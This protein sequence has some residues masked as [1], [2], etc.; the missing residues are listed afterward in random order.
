MQHLRRVVSLW[1][2]MDEYTHNL[3]K[4][5]AS[6]GP[7]EVTFFSAMSVLPY[8]AALRDLMTPQELFKYRVDVFTYKRDSSRDC[9]KYLKLTQAG[10]MLSRSSVPDVSPLD[11]RA[12]ADLAAAE[13]TNHTSNHLPQP[14]KPATPKTPDCTIELLTPLPSAQAHGGVLDLTKHPKGDITAMQ[15]HVAPSEWVV[16]RAAVVE[17]CKTLSEMVLQGG[18]RVSLSQVVALELPEALLRWLDGQ[19]QRVPW[20]LDTMLSSTYVMRS[21]VVSADGQWENDDVYISELGF[22]AE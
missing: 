20:F 19:G 3:A 17:F 6:Q 15:S 18:Q 16:F 9:D 2:K 8:S 14:S 4:H 21:D 1:D 12:L 22:V 10:V 7:Q 13:G 11:L 5:I